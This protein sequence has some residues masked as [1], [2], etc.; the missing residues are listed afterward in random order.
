MVMDKTEVSEQRRIGPGRADLLGITLS[1][2]GSGM[3]ASITLVL[4]GAL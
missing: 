2:S 4:D 1:C 3:V